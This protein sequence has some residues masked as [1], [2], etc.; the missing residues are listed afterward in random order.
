MSTRSAGWHP[1]EGAGGWL[2]WWDGTGWRDAYWPDGLPAN[3]YLPD[4]PRV[5]I[6][7]NTEPTVDVVGENWRENEIVAALGTRPARDQET[8]AEHLVG[9]LVPEP[10]NPHDNHAVSIRVHGH[11][12]GYLDREQAREYFDLVSTFVSSGFVPTV[13]VRIW[14]VTRFVSAR[15]QDEVKSSVRIALPPM[16]AVRPDNMPPA[17]PYF[18]IPRGRSIQVTGES[19]HFDVLSRY[20]KKGGTNVLVTLAPITVATARNDK[21]LVEVLLDGA[22]VGQ[23]TPATSASL[24]PL[25]QEAQRQNRLAVA[26]ATIVGSHLAAEVTLH[27]AR[28]QDTPSTWPS[29]AD[30]LP[31]PGV[32]RGSVPS[33]YVAQ[34]EPI[35]APVGK[36]L[37]MWMWILGVVIAL[38][39]SYI[40]YVGPL[41][42]IVFV[43]LLVIVHILRKRRPPGNAYE[44]PHI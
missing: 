4:A 33:A 40:P 20:V 11:C 26:W 22:R 30:V 1:A 27:V 38:L 5:D 29:S 41:I 21:V 9:E 34:V 24:L 35:P 17:A 32:S 12:I 42:T 8:I 13:R 44:G 7:G 25:I 15:N 36:G 31:Q 14:A 2:R 18:L 3:E 37:T 43:V 28:A 39:F 19:E 23:L 6:S 16:S 10:D